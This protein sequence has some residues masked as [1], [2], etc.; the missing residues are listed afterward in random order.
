VL[1]DRLNLLARRALSKI[2]GREEGTLRSFNP[3]PQEQL[4]IS[5]EVV[6]T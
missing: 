1:T 2:G 4:L 6:L 3:M 5:P